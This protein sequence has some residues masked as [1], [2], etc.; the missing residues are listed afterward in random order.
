M[1]TWVFDGIRR[2]V[3]LGLLVRQGKKRSFDRR[4]SPIVDHCPSQ[5][6]WVRPR[7]PSRQAGT[8]DAMGTL[9]F[10]AWKLVSCFL[11]AKGAGVP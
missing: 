9:G 8:V 1:A 10:V 11:P 5:W 2:P 3:S 4:L 7:A 6:T